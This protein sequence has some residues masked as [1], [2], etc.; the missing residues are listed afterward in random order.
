MNT[1]DPSLNFICPMCGAKA[2][3]HC[4]SLN[5]D[6]RSESHRERIVKD[7]A[8]SGIA[9]GASLL[10]YVVWLVGQQHLQGH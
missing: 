2:T 3:K 8:I 9:E 10:D 1:I 5:G 7:H 6:L 4:E